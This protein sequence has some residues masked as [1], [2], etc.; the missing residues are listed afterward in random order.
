M[1]IA[2]TVPLYALVVM[3]LAS[4]GRDTS[5]PARDTLDTVD[6]GPFSL[7][8]CGTAHA[9]GDTVLPHASPCMNFPS[10]STRNAVE[11]GLVAF[12]GGGAA[13]WHI[14]SVITNAASAR[15]RSAVSEELQYS[16]LGDSIILSSPT[17]GPIVLLRSG[18]D[19]VTWLRTE[20]VARDL[21][22]RRVRPVAPGEYHLAYCGKV[23]NDS[24]YIFFAPPPCPNG[25]GGSSSYVVDSGRVQ[26]G[27]DGS[28]SW[29]LGNTQVGPGSGR[30][31]SVDTLSGTMT[32]ASRDTVLLGNAVAGRTI[33]LTWDQKNT[34]RALTNTRLDL[35]FA[36]KPSP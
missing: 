13:K 16:V 14:E 20:R 15:T 17:Q 2:A 36:L 31:P 10:T 12:E 35:Y 30:Y 28:M 3:V 6:L 9:T 34:L 19:E 4:C 33:R 8:A 7:V 29:M 25:G 22:F 23:Y 26:V 5:A 24:L 18:P 32:M 21:V 1:R 11:A 27:S